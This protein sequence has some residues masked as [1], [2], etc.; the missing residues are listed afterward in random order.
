MIRENLLPDILDLKIKSYI[1][2][3]KQRKV[4]AI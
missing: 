1:C 3:V 2:I 4:Y